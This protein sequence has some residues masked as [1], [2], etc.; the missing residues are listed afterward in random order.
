M[1]AITCGLFP[2]GEMGDRGHHIMPSLFCLEE[3]LSFLTRG[4]GFSVLDCGCEAGLEEAGLHTTPDFQCCCC[5]VRVICC[6]SIKNHL[7]SYQPFQRS[8]TQLCVTPGV[9]SPLGSASL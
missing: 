5:E 6:L 2:S 9:S 1:E 4:Q 8:S 7:C 3:P